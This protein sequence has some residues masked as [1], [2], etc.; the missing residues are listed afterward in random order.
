MAGVTVRHQLLPVVTEVEIVESERLHDGRY[1]LEVIGRRR[2]RIISHDEMDGYQVARVTYDPPT[3]AADVSGDGSLADVVARA[4]A[5][6]SEWVARLAAVGPERQAD[7]LA[8]AG[9]RP[10]PSAT[11]AFSWWICNLLPIPASERAKLLL[12][13]DAFERLRRAVQARPLFEWFLC[14][15]R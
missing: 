12:A 8:R 10:P 4:D 3:A 7:Y 13:K 6:A 1:H 14:R 11:E 2:A 5:L 15:F 9:E